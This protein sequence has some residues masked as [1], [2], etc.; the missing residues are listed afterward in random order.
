VL[1]LKKPKRVGGLMVI[2]FTEEA[3]ISLL[4]NDGASKPEFGRYVF[5]WD[6]RALRA[7]LY[8]R[9]NFEE[10][11]SQLGIDVGDVD[12]FDFPEL[13]KL[14][15]SAP[16]V[17]PPATGA[18]PMPKP[19]NVPHSQAPDLHSESVPSVASLPVPR[20]LTENVDTDHSEGSGRNG[21]VIGAVVVTCLL[22][23]LG[24]AKLLSRRARSGQ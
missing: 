22:A 17:V 4:D 8:K 7:S 9:K 19:K 6:M 14:A 20:S 5:Y 23:L 12:D 16:P 15:K 1:A 13:A 10:L 2:G 3:D 24:V 11:V 21:V 18:P